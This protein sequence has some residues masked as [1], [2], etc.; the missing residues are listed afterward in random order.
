M[1]TPKKNAPRTDSFHAPS[2]CQKWNRT[3]SWILDNCACSP[4][5][6]SVVCV[7]KMRYL[8]NMYSTGE[9]NGHCVSI[10]MYPN[11]VVTIIHTQVPIPSPPPSPQP[12]HPSP[13]PPPNTHTHTCAHAHMLVYTFTHMHRRMHIHAHR[14]GIPI[15]FIGKE[16]WISKQR[17][18]IV[19]F[20]RQA[21][22]FEVWRIFHRQWL[23]SD[24]C[25]CC[26]FL[27][28]FP[29]CSSVRVRQR[30]EDGN[31]FSHWLHVKKK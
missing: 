16:W 2:L 29:S 24:H 13:P 12:S 27:G 10:V 4:K 30:G 5:V 21:S 26:Y 20:C 14:L 18:L 22:L 25:S 19:V 17:W 28:K 1:S 9:E 11:W 31:F 7:A 6:W 15:L 23:T 8:V 3:I